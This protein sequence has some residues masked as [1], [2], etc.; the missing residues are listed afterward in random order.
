MAGVRKSPLPHGR[1]QGY[2]LDYA[3]KRVFSTGTHSREDTRRMADRLEDEHRQIRLG[4]RPVPK[5]TDKNK[6]RPFSEVRDEYLAWGRTQGGR[7]GWPWSASHAG[8]ME[9]YLRWWET[10]LGLQTMAD[11][12]GLLARAEKALREVAAKGRARATLRN[13]AGALGAFGRWCVQRGYVAEDPLRGLGRFDTTPRVTRRAMT[14]DE[15]RKLL[16]CC[17][18]SRRLCYEMAFVSG[19]RR[20]E[21]AALTAG[22]LD[23]ERGGVR[24]DPAWTKDRKGGF[25]RL[26]AAL[27]TKLA[28]TC[29]GKN[30]TDKLLQVPVNA[31]RDMDKDLKA[32]GIPKRTFL[33]KLDFHACRVAYVSYVMESGAS[34]KE[35]MSLARHATPDLTLNVY[36]RARE[37]RLGEVVEAVGKLALPEP[38]SA[39]GVQ[40]QAVGA[41]VTVVTPF[42]PME[43]GQT[44]MVETA[45]IEPA[46]RGRSARVSTHVVG[47]WV[48]PLTA[49][50]DR[51]DQ[52]PAQLRISP[53]PRSAHEQ[54]QPAVV[55][56]SSLA[57]KTRRT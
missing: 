5:S 15:I 52:A 8:D 39:I 43:L 10:R 57:G 9:R 46:S 42:S 53:R 31:A 40:R 13:H 12:D 28:A 37:D 24:L 17:E 29:A 11:F 35:A 30:P 23:V 51:L 49:P 55:V 41:E 38:E 34:V 22:D 44:K 48:S 21:L 6:A 54:G 50:A 20:G 47:L 32:A 45:G 18:P 56:L 19:L 25:Q 7:G 27:V 4:H 26:P 36:G 14:P 3:G 1:Y 33:G 16:E 2:F